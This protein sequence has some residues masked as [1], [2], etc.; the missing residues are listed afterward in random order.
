MITLANTSRFLDQY[1]VTV[2]GTSQYLY[3]DDPT[4]KGNTLGSISFWFK[5][6][7]LFAANGFNAMIGYGVKDAMNDAT[8]MIGPRRLTATGTGTYLNILTRTTNGGTN[9]GVIAT[10]TPLVAGTWMRATVQT[11][12]S[13][14]S[15]Y[16]NGTL[17]ALTTWIGTNT[18]DWFGDISGTSHRLV[19]GAN[20]V[21]NAIGSNYYP[22]KLN[23]GIYVN[24]INTGPEA[25]ALYNGGV[26]N[27]PFRTIAPADVKAWWQ[28]EQNG[29]DVMGN[30]NLTAV[31]SPTYATP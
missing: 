31:G 22:G 30:N 8:M 24:R 1:A 13:A 21:S 2:N 4:F 9:N 17:Q 3:V 27:N 10:T 29:L 7:A 11:D 23:E 25:A 12:G 26:P 28:F 15:I 14:W 6:D 18:G 16:I 5:V 20:Y 19:V